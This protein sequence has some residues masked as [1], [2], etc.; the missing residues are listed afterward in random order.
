MLSVKVEG[1]KDLEKALMQ[2]KDTTAKAT[3]RRAGKKALEPTAE[4]AVQLAP[5]NEASGP[6]HLKDS[7]SISTKATRTAEKGKSRVEIYCGVH[8]EQSKVGIQQEYGNIIHGPQAFMRPAWDQTKMQVLA[9]FTDSMWEET[10]KSIAR[11]E[12]KAAR[13]AAR[14]G[15]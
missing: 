6:Y 10:K 5:F 12:R 13:D 1:L 14:A 3:V 11:A 9:R 2:L 4:K 15:R 7:I 8:K